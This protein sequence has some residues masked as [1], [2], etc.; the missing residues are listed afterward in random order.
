MT[1]LLLAVTVLIAPDKPHIPFGGP[2]FK[3]YY[4]SCKQ[5]VQGRNPYDP[6]GVWR[7]QQALGA[8]AVQ[9]PYGPPT[10]LLPFIPLGW[11]DFVTAVQTF[12]VV[13]IILMVLSCF[14]WG[15]MLFPRSELLPML[16][17]VTVVAWM[18]SMTLFGLGQV[19]SFV[20]FGFTL[21]IFLM[22]R[23]YPVAA[24]AV[25]ALTIIKPHL[26]AG[27][28]LYAGIVGLRHKHWRMLVALV[29]TGLLLAAAPL[30]IRPTIWGEYFEWMPT[31]QEYALKWHK[32]TLDGRLRVLLTQWLPGNTDAYYLRLS[33]LLTL[34][35][36]LVFAGW[37][38]LLAWKHPLRSINALLVLVLWTAGTFYAFS[39]DFILLCPAFI[40]AL[41]HA[42]S[43]SKPAWALAALGW[44]ILTVTY[45]LIKR[46]GSDHGWFE[47]HFFYIPWGALALT[48]LLLP[49]EEE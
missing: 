38:G 5:I 40:L 4:A 9:V 45:F 17:I 42:V 10:S 21:W 19:T 16:A 32:A 49:H 3:Q 41:G 24:G 44:I 2:D 29:V 6:A 12:F 34:P 22:R 35:I 14:L 46:L 43:R 30:L 11:L 25:L 36:V 39:Y 27:P 48:L 37:I 8:D 20:L 31:A 7:I 13:N 26:A 23:G 28:L 15:K 18:P 1:A 33:Q 47:Y